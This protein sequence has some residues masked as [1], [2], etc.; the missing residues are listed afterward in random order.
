MR[1]IGV[2]F[3]CLSAALFIVGLFY[4]P[5]PYLVFLSAMFF[6]GATSDVKKE[7]YRLIATNNYLTKDRSD[8]MEEKVLLVSPKTKI[9]KVCSSLRGPYLYRIVV[10][11]GSKKIACLDEQAIEKMFFVERD[12]SMGEFLVQNSLVGV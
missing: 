2:V 3:G 10:V 4:R 9:R 12:M 5:V 11:S 7:M 6:I 8:P 1:V